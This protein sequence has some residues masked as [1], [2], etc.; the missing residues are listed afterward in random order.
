M[1]IAVVYLFKLFTFVY[2][3]K[4]IIMEEIQIK[5]RNEMLSWAVFIGCMFLGMGIGEIYDRGGVGMFVGLGVGYIASALIEN[6][7][8]N[9]S[10]SKIS[11]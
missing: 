9:S 7:K 11:G 5:E 4:K 2:L 3:F 6:I 10:Q 8:R 1:A